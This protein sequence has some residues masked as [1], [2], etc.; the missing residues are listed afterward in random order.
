VNSCV[1]LDGKAFAEKNKAELSRKV[2]KL[3]MTWED[4]HL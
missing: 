3:K 2:S 4:R 1:V